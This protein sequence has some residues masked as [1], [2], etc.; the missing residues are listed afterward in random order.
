MTRISRHLARKVQ[1]RLAAKMSTPAA[2][3]G[4]LRRLSLMQQ[5]R[6]ACIDCCEADD[7]PL[8]PR[9]TEDEYSL[10]PDGEPWTLQTARWG[11]RPA[12]GPAHRLC[13]TCRRASQVAGRG[14]PGP[15]LGERLRRQGGR[16]RGRPGHRARSPGVDLDDRLD[17]DS[18]DKGVLYIW[19]YAGQPSGTWGISE[20]TVDRYWILDAD[21]RRVVLPA[22][23]GAQADKGLLN[24][25]PA[26]SKKPTS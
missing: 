24:C 6:L 13:S 23:L 9:Y 22:S 16:R 19:D 18:C 2:V 17:F 8:S 10:P 1:A 12:E 25:S 26:W 20:P 5:G 21:G 14:L 4:H 15:V 3:A 7:K 11:V